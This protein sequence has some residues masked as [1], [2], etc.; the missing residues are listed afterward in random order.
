MIEPIKD[1]IDDLTL[2]PSEREH[3]PRWRL[4]VLDML[5][6]SLQTKLSKESNIVSNQGCEAIKCSQ[7]IK[8][9]EVQNDATK[10]S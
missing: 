10:E 6:Q 2:T 4:I 9:K 7:I 8:I 5:I 3:V 1:L